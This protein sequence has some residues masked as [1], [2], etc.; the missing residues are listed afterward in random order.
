MCISVSAIM[1]ISVCAII[2][3]ELLIVIKSLHLK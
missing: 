1:C 2:F 3:Y